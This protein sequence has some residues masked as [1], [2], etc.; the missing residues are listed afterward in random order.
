MRRSL[1]DKQISAD[2]RG[3]LAIK[4]LFVYAVQF[5]EKIAQRGFHI[6][7]ETVIQDAGM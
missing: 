2:P 4:G 3:E 6:R 1:S 5:G 7:S